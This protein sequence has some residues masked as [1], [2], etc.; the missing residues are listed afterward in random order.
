MRG[1]YSESLQ[2]IEIWIKSISNAW[3]LFGLGYEKK[4]LNNFVVSGNIKV[5]TNLKLCAR[6]RE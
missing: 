5:E 2:V 1:V 4:G 3:L 6:D